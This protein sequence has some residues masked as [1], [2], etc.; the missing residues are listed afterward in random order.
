MLASSTTT[1]QAEAEQALTTALAAALLPH[2]QVALTTTAADTEAARALELMKRSAIAPVMK[3][4]SPPFKVAP[5]LPPG[6]MPR[7]TIRRVISCATYLR[8]LHVTGEMV[9]NGV[10]WV[11]R[12]R[13]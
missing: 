7:F 4:S 5:P 9:R 3:P 1:K 10:E 11:Q 2:F 8:R 6:A 12:E 13:G